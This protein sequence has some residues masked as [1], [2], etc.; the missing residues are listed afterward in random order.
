MDSSN[1]KAIIL[2]SLLLSAFSFNVEGKASCNGKRFKDNNALAE[3]IES[4][5]S[6][7]Q[8]QAENAIG[9]TVTKSLQEPTVSGKGRCSKKL[10]EKQCES[11][12]DDAIK[13]IRR[14]C[15]NAFAASVS[16]A[17]CSISYKTG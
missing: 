6:L 10:S 16:G 15:K 1:I 5:L 4:I 13:D 2:I 9:K 12:M 11:C 3:R 14:G 17:K 7:V 8:F